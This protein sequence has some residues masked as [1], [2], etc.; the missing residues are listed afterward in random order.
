[1]NLNVLICGVLKDTESLLSNNLELAIETGKLFNKYKI[2]I[3][4]NN[5]K[6]NT[7]T[8]LNNYKSNSNFL[9]FS[10]DIPY[11]TIKYNSRIWSYKEITG[12]DHPCRIEQI[13]KARNRIVDEINKEE[14]NEYE[15]VIW[16][17]LDSNGWSLEGILD[18]FEKKDKWDVIYANGINQQRNYYDLYAL[19]TKSRLF[20][21]ESLGENFWN[22]LGEERYEETMD[23]IPVYSAFGGLGIY[24]KSIF[25]MCRFDFLVNNDVKVF[26]RKQ[27]DET[28]LLIKTMECLQNKDSKFPKGYKDE[29]SCIFWKANSGYDGPVICE[30]IPL[31]L[32][33]VNKG[34]R[35]F[36]NP[37]MIYLY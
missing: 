29:A 27:L 7:K 30:H 15:Y 23:L 8:I 3:Y 25:K 36:I 12:S 13:C 33:L 32:K 14:Y 20:G 10:E 24:K 1:M 37:K 17:D 21:P 26:Y 4:E 35:I 9:I 18:S 22:K 6:D 16:I 2:I 5:S 11:D 19:R 28:P 34:Y 31:N